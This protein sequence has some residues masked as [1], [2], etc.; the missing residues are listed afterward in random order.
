MLNA[1]TIQEVCQKSGKKILPKRNPTACLASAMLKSSSNQTSLKNCQINGGWDDWCQFLK[2]Q[3][4]VKP[5]SKQQ[6]HVVKIA[7]LQSKCTNLGPR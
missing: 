1:N 7:K 6:S 2:N 3:K 5:S 4:Q